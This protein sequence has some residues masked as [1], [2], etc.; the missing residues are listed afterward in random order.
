M[1]NTF[2]LKNALV[3][4]VK[5]Y[6]E[7]MFVLWLLLFE[8]WRNQHNEIGVITKLM[9]KSILKVYRAEY[10]KMSYL[11][12]SIR[13]WSLLMWNGNQLQSTSNNN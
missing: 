8:I 10:Y 2:F 11:L 4:H 7:K 9:H 6:I 1:N 5:Y 3:A 12:K 13:N